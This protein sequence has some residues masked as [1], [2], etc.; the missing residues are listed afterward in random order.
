MDFLLSPIWVQIHDMPL[1]CMNRS[2]G[3]QIGSSMGKVEDVVEAED[4]VG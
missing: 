1:G 4:D 3:T 2:V